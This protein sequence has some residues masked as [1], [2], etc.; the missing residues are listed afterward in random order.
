MILDIEQIKNLL[1]HR[2]P[3]LFL[4]SCKILEKGKKGIGY[5]KFTVDEYFFKGHFP[6]NPIVPGVV[7]IETIAQTAGVVV[8]ESL[9]NS[10]DKSVLFTSVSNAKFR[11]PVKPDDDIIIK[12]ELINKVKAV[13]KFHGEAMNGQNRICEAI[14]SAMILNKSSSEIL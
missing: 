11:K 7:L 2:D 1:P 10:K 4:D 3:F 13:Y 6:N 5:K 12:V 8:S 14:F 9:A